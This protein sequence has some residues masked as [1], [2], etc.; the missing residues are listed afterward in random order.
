MVQTM[1]RLVNDFN[2]SF[3]AS[4]TTVMAVTLNYLLPL[5][6]IDFKEAFLTDVGEGY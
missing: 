5:K 1:R 3:Q 6:Y 2:V 4:R